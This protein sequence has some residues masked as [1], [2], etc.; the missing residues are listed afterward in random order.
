MKSFL[1]KFYRHLAI[2][3]WSHCQ[4]ETCNYKEG[5]LGH[6][7]LHKNLAQSLVFKFRRK[8][9]FGKIWW[10]WQVSQLD[11]SQTFLPW[12][13]WTEKMVFM[14][15]FWCAQKSFLFNVKL[16]K[17]IKYAQNLF[18]Y[19]VQQKQRQPK[20]LGEEIFWKYFWTD[21]RIPPVANHI[22]YYLRMTIN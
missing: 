5:L 12:A 19:F 15:N 3:F 10:K 2:L 7:V 20:L 11:H 1:G 21:F 18:P 8:L 22:K 14:K 9:F 6:W 17:F 4:R 16:E 13:F